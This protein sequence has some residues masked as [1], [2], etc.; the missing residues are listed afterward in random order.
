MSIGGQREHHNRASP[1]ALTF[2]GI[3]RHLI[4]QKAHRS[5][6]LRACVVRPHLNISRCIADNA[7]HHVV[8]RCGVVVI[9]RVSHKH[10]RAQRCR[11]C[12]NRDVL[13]VKRLGLC[14]EKGDNHKVAELMAIHRPSACYGQQRGYI[15]LRITVVKR[16]NV[17]L[18]GGQSPVQNLAL[19]GI[20]DGPA[21]GRGS[22]VVGNIL[23]RSRSKLRKPLLCLTYSS[24]GII[25]SPL[26]SGSRDYI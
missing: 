9:S 24:S 12:A 4:H 20:E 7:R 18:G 8:R 22:Q 26:N 11:E 6:G 14:C 15:L 19:V 21:R 1:S 23:R 13:V 17:A 3:D 10:D 2:S 5:A 25:L 16:I